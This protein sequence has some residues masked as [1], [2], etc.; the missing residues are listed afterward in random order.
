MS[1]EV[2]KPLPNEAASTEEVS[3]AGTIDGDSVVAS[4]SEQHTSPSAADSTLEENKVSP[5]K[6]GA[7]LLGSAPSKLA[8]TVA[9][10]SMVLP[11]F[12]S[13]IIGEL[14]LT[15]LIPIQP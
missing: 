14:L 9:T 8:N 15:S 6:N 13:S 7:G 2:D 3:N 11:E 5:I 4:A 1:T 10:V 12:S